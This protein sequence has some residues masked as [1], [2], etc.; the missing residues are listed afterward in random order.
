M[1]LTVVCDVTVPRGTAELLEKAL[2]DRF[3]SRGCESADFTMRFSLD[4]SVGDGYTLLPDT[5]SVHIT[6]GN[7]SCLFSAAGEFL[8]RSSFDGYGGFQPYRK[9]VKHSFAEKLR[10]MYYATHFRNFWHTAPPEEVYETVCDLAFRGC[11]ALLVWFDMHHFSGIGE[12][13]AMEMITRLREILACAESF[14]M[15]P[16]LL[17]LANEG[18]SG[19]PDSLLAE[20]AAENGYHIPPAGFYGTEICPS[21]PGGKA[22]ILR[23]RREVLEAFSGIAL[24]YICLWPYDQG[25]CTCKSCAPWGINGY[26]KLIPETAELAEQFFPQAEIIVSTWFFDRFTAGEWAGMS[27]IMKKGLPS[28]AEYV[29]AYFF[30]GLPEAISKNGIPENVKFISFPEISMQGAVPW[31]G[32]G[33]NPLPEFLRKNSL[34]EIFRGGFPYSEG[35]FD[36]INKWICL[37]QFS[38]REENTADSVRAYLKHEFCCDSETLADAVLLMEKTLPRSVYRQDGVIRCD[39]SCPP[40]V[41]KIYREVI[42]CDAALPERIRSG[43][44]WRLIYCRAVIDRE[45]VRTSGAPADSEEYRDRVSELIRLYHAENAE[46]YVKP[47]L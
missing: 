7:P 46:E 20:N 16:S 40:P 21:V 15:A 37:R 14:G 25:G 8:C 3:A 35:I 47:P 9:A 34:P 30:D 24:K 36:D 38:Y 33:A 17:M 45:I 31:G 1:P 44:K 12:P 27:R 19:T 28:G 29:M 13:D 43:W 5:G 41:E 4:G 22:A 6:G 32:F 23:E 18:F 11:N 26:M 42:K 2:K 39:I 10:G